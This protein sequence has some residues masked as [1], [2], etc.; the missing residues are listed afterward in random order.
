MIDELTDTLFYDAILIPG[1]VEIP[2][3]SEDF[4]YCNALWIRGHC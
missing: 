2:I 1:I 3:M 4:F